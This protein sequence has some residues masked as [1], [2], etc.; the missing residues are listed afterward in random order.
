MVAILNPKSIRTARVDAFLSHLAIVR[1][2][3]VTSA[4]ARSCQA[5][6]A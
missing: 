5:S 6:A 3:Y 2:I 4:E 1:E